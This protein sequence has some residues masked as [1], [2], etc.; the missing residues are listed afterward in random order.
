MKKILIHHHE[1]AYSDSN[2][3]WVRGYFGHWVSGLAKYFTEI[4][5]LLHESPKILPSQDTCIS[6]Q[7]VVLQS[8]GPRRKSVNIIKRR[9]NII[10]KC[11]EMRNYD[12]LLIRGMTPNQYTVFKYCNTP[13]KGFLLIQ[14]LFPPNQ[15]L[16]F[17]ME[18]VIEFLFWKLR[19]YQYRLISKHALLLANSPTLCEEI[20][21]FTGLNSQFVST[22]IIDSKDIAKKHP[23][24]KDNC[25][26]IN[27]LFVGRIVKDKGILELIEAVKILN[28]KNTKVFYL[29]VIGSFNDNNFKNLINDKIKAE[30]LTD[31]IK[32]YGYI[33]YGEELF[34]IY[35]RGDILVLPSY[36]EGFPQIIWEAFVSKIPVITTD[37]GGISGFLKNDKDALLILPQDVKQ[38]VDAVR[39]LIADRALKSLLVENGFNMVMEHTLEKSAYRLSQI[40]RKYA[41]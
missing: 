10:N 8:L 16:S 2:G 26:Q 32:F 39:K 13:N 35:H 18:S 31:R 6:M 21:C 29:N 19:K 5:L 23:K 11:R 37:V 30:N 3:I 34:N 1:I 7:N 36:H 40:I 28:K 25:N 24:K 4:G 27:L 17:N 15:T 38:I 12:I 20:K 9:I 41:K 22:S 14:S 33:S